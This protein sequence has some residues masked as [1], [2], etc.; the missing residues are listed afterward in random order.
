MRSPAGLKTRN[1]ETTQVVGCLDGDL[2]GPPLE[3]QIP[4]AR[5]KA[6]GMTKSK[7]ALGM[8]ESKKALGM[9]KSKKA[10]GMTQSK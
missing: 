10:L 8:T 1:L 6:L 9:T 2:S 4:R 7:K 5:K 3:K